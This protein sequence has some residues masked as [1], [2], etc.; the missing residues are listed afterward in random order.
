MLETIGV[1]YS[2]HIW[3]TRLL[4]IIQQFQQNVN[5]KVNF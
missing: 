4:D 1:G 5:E 2:N 3:D